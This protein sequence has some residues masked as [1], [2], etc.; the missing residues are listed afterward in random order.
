MMDKTK[1]IPEQYRLTAGMAPDKGITQAWP[2]PADES[3][4]HA[5]DLWWR[6]HYVNKLI[7]GGAP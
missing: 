3:S 2:R 4:T 1:G 6:H 7:S 5:D